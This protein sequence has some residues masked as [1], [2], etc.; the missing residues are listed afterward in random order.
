MGQGALSDDTSHHLHEVARG[1]STSGGR[2]AEPANKTSSGSPSLQRS[3]YKSTVSG[4]EEGWLSSTSYQ[5]KATE[6]VC[7]ETAFQDGGIGCGEGSAT[8]R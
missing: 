2:S 8:A 7:A 4:E 1:L 3:I 5:F 6:W